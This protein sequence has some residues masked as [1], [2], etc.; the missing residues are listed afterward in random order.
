M[1]SSSI[2]LESRTV[3]PQVKPVTLVGE[4][5]LSVTLARR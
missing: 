5:G 2:R 3:L 1:A 4:G